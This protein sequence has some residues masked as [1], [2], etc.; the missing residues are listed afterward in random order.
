[1]VKYPANAHDPYV[2][3]KSGV[4]K[5][6]LGIVDDAILQRVEASLTFLRSYEV[7]RTPVQGA[8]DLAHLQAIHKRLFGDIYDW[9]GQIRTVDISKG[10]TRFAS[11]QQIESYAPEITRPLQRERYLRGLDIDMF[12]QRA[13]HYLGEFNVLHPFREGNGRSIREFISQLARD[14]GYAL[15]WTGIEQAEMIQA[16]IEAYQGDSSHL[17]RIIRSRI[18]DLGQE[19]GLNT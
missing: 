5:N 16:S 19:R 17:A 8:F 12:C 9:A 4:L 6:R 7:A 11:F 13:G 14:A 18:T 2:D 1:M 3:Q 15:N 10:N